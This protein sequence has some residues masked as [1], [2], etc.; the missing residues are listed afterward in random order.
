MKNLFLTMWVL[1][2]LVVWDGLNAQTVNLI[3]P[4]TNATGASLTET[5]TWSTGGFGLSE[6]STVRVYEDAGLLMLV[7][8]S[9]NLGLV[10]SFA[11]PP[12]TLEYNKKYFWVVE[13]DD[14]VNNVVSL[15]FAFTTELATPVLL[16]PANEFNA[17]GVSPSFTFSL[18]ENKSNV[19]YELLVGTNPGLGS[20]ADVNLTSTINPGTLELTATGLTGATK[21]YWTINAK[22]DDGGA[23]NNGEEKTAT[24][25]R[26]FYTP[27]NNLT[28]P[29]NG[30][31]GHTLEPTFSWSD[32]AWETGYEL[33]ISTAGN[34]QAAFDAGVIFTDLA[35]ASGTTSVSYDENSENE[36]PGGMYPFPLTANTKYYW[37]LTAKDGGAGVSSPIWH[38]TT[39]PL[40]TVSLYNPDNAAEVYLTDVYFSYGI[41][42]GTTGLKFKLQV[43]SALTEP[44]KT[45]WLTSDF[46]G[47]ST[48]LFQNVSLAGGT[49]YYWRVVLLNNSDKVLA[50]SETRHFTTVGGAATPIPSWPVESGMVYT[51]TPTLYWYMNGFSYNLTYDIEVAEDTTGAAD[52]SYTNLS[53]TYHTLLSALNPGTTYFWRVRSVYKRGL[54]EEETSAFSFWSQGKFETYPAATSVVPNPSYPT[55]NLEVYTTTPTFYW[56]LG[57]SGTGLTYS[58][59]YST[60]NTFATHTR[61]ENISSTNVLVSGL[62]PGATYYW[63]VKTHSA[64]DSS[65]YSAVATFS[66]AGG[67]TNSYPVATWPIASGLDIP[68]VYTTTP[69]LLWYLEGASLG[70]SGYEVRWKAGSNSS[71]WN[72][73]YDGSTTVS[74]ASNTSYTFV[75]ALDNGT[76][77]YWGVAATG[78]NTWSEGAFTIYSNGASGQPILNYPISGDVI[79]TK[80]PTMSWYFNGSTSG[81]VG[82]EVVYSYSD[83]F[84]SGATTTVYVTGTSYTV[85]VDLVQGA[86]YWWKVRAH[87][88]GAV[89][90]GYST[91]EEFSVFPGSS[92]PIQPI[93]GGPHNVSIGTSAPMIS[94]VNPVG[95]TSG[96]IYE[97]EYSTN[98]SFTNATVVGNIT[99][100]FIQVN[101]L[102]SNSAYFWRVRSKNPEGNYSFYSNMGMF[103]VIEGTTGVEGNE[104]IPENYQLSQNFPNPFNPVTVIKYQLPMSG[105]V[106]LKIYDVLGKEVATLVNET[107]QAGSYTI[108][109][110]GANLA[111]GV[112]YYK[113]SAGE[114]VSVKKMV[115]MK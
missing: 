113:I 83:V 4:A 14:G 84:A 55:D 104:Q 26:V 80:T 18:D 65:D 13:T 42:G 37:Q 52:Y 72:S 64:T 34:N 11:L 107:Q 47:V 62:V 81:I 102:S 28:A 46:S 88:G 68:V 1:V 44:V 71:N 15:P 58:L 114:F 111:S 3:S 19:K 38:F 51:Y 70:I 87:L 98:P 27:I 75:S 108:N 24:E 91:T 97:L 31:T 69:Q 109:F 79:Y 110:N 92:A 49:K 21:Y 7:F 89:Y 103:R 94:W 12:A 32:L 22:V 82:Y 10:N 86:T 48:A 99:G 85:A 17:S 53:S 23:D 66:V 33:R 112:Y 90:S 5:L 76:T 56:W 35:I 36:G 59:I 57:V 115:L 106:S 54:P 77:Y 61:I 9:G 50:Y 105:N 74:G 30:V 39:Y 67:T 41:S 60:D 8:D 63:K 96:L 93:A 6:A 40:V 29:I 73:D 78:G 95:S 43:K 101:N 45:D 25:E 100:N 20:P 16:T 2:S